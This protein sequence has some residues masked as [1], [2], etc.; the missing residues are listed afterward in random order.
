MGK[1][2]VKS[3]VILTSIL[4]GMGHIVNLFNGN[5]E[6]LVATSCQLFYAAAAGF[7]LA[8]VLIASKSIIPC[9]ITHSMLNA[10]G[11]FSNETAHEKIQIPVSI[12]LCVIS[13]VSAYLIFRNYKCEKLGEI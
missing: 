2:N 3:A 6:D 1:D 12:A 7:L 9:M 8:A 10:L 4:F 13:G 5:S 11:T